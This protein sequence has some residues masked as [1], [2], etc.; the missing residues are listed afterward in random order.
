MKFE[1]EREIKDIYEDADQILYWLKQY[2]LTRLSNV[3][4]HDLYI[5]L[6]YVW[7]MLYELVED[8]EKRKIKE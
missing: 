4:I 7:L 3:Q 2:D 6:S 5:K 1:R 8:A